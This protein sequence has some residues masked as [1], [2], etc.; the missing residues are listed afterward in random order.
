MEKENENKNQFKNKKKYFKFLKF[1]KL[2]N[3]LKI[4]TKNKIYITNLKLKVV[5]KIKK[6]FEKI[7]I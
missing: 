7:N 6:I 3:V 2:K 4:I 5:E 1:V